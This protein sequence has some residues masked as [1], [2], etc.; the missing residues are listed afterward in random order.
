MCFKR[1]I[2]YFLAGHSL[3]AISVSSSRMTCGKL[4]FRTNLNLPSEKKTKKMKVKG[5]QNLRMFSK[6][7]EQD[8]SGNKQKSFTVD[9]K[10]K[11]WSVVFQ[12]QEIQ[13]SMKHLKYTS[14]QEQL[15]FCID[16]K[17]IYGCYVKS[18]TNSGSSI[19]SHL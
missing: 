16:M 1:L 3:S 9:L 18:F 12:A 7:R 10:D 2:L 11:W 8:K 14:R 15:L 19:P 17:C 13:I 6:M 5:K 4:S